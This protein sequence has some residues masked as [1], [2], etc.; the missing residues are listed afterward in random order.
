MAPRRC[1]SSRAG[2][3]GRR[4]PLARIVTSAVAGVDPSIMGIGPIPATRK[5]L[6]RAGLRVDDI[7]LIELNEAFAAQSTR[8]HARTRAGSGEGQR[9]TAAPSRWAIRSARPASRAC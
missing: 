2:A 7:D 1:C 4:Q 5:A 3:D 6:A 8:V 9:R